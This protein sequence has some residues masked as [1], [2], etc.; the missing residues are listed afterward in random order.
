MDTIRE[1]KTLSGITYSEA[2]LCNMI[3]ENDRRIESLDNNVKYLK[4]L[5]VMM[6]ED[7]HEMLEK[8]NLLKDK[9]KKQEEAIKTNTLKA[10]TLKQVEP[11][12]PM[13]AMLATECCGIGPITDENYCSKCGAKIVR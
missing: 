8:I 13:L 11:N 10:T 1:Y 12:N 7:M 5:Y 4:G 6:K 9:D 3:I 2:E